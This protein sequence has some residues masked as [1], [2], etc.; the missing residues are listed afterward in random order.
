MLRPS[1]KRVSDGGLASGA[2]DA[3]RSL[4]RPEQLILGPP[5]DAVALAGDA[6]EAGPVG[7]LDAAPLVAD[8][9]RLLELTSRDGDPGPAHPE[10]HGQ[11]LVGHRVLVP[12]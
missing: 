8:E 3:R 6:L 1:G 10:H 11:E 5:D 7:D 4:G 9:A 12:L 2:I